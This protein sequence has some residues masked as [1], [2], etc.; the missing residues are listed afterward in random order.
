[1]ETKRSTPPSHTRTIRRVSAVSVMPVIL[2]GFVC[3][4]MAEKIGGGFLGGF[5]QGATIALMILGAYLAGSAIW[6]RR[7]R[8]AQLDAGGE[9]LPSRDSVPTGSDAG[10]SAGSGVS[11]EV[12]LTVERRTAND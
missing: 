1:M 8:A 6:P 3:Y 7:K 12:N 11:S 2:I 4:L 5:F 9:W 10:T